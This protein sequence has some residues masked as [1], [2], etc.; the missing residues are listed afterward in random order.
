MSTQTPNLGLTKPAGNERPY[1]SVINDN[2]DILDSKIGAVGNT[3]LQ[4]QVT[5]LGESVSNLIKVV[6]LTQ[7]YTVGANT[8]VQVNFTPTLTG[9]RPV[10]MIGY[11]TGNASVMMQQ[12]RMIDATTLRLYPRNLLNS[13]QTGTVIVEVLFLKQ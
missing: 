4:S 13:Q 7:E 6:S 5:A 9:Y 1:R 3:D 10:G 12:C 8:T 2:M 11:T